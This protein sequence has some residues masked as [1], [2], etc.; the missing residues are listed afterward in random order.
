[1]HGLCASHPNDPTSGLNDGPL[2]RS[3]LGELPEGEYP[4]CPSSNGWWV[5]LL[6]T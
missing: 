1:M 3:P 2:S 6:G 4:C 5:E